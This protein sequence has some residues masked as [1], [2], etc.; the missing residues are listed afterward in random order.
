MKNKLIVKAVDFNDSQLMA[1]QDSETGKIYVGVSWICNGLAFNKGQKDT[2]VEKIQGDVVLKQGCRKFPAGVFDPH[3]ETIAIELD[4]LPL[5]L[6]KISIT[7]K[8]QEEQPEVTKNLVEYQ[9]KAKDI[10]AAA[11]LPKA[12][13]SSTN[14]ISAITS[15]AKFITGI[16]KE[17]GMPAQ[18]IAVNT[19]RLY[20]PVGIEISLD[21]ITVEKH[22]FDATT[23]AKRFGMQSKTGKPH[24][25]AVSAIIAKID[26]RDDEK[27]VVPFQNQQSGH[28]GTN[29]QY[30]ESVIDKIELWL[31]QNNYPCQIKHNEKTYGVYYNDRED[32]KVG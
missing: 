30:A 18:F 25:Q 29:Y 26:V 31:K 5:W 17:A 2:Q 27:E 22:L 4:F 20:E 12:K 23:I 16:L 1:A 13:K 3:N 14:S 10:L 15:A 9:L 6:A 28:S 24:N 19:K 21:G 32:I 8:M 11:F 7:P